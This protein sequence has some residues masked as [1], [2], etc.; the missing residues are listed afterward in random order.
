M[1]TGASCVPRPLQGPTSV[2][3]RLLETEQPLDKDIQQLCKCRKLG[4]LDFYSIF[5]PSLPYISMAYFW[6]G[7][8]DFDPNSKNFTHIL[9]ALALY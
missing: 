2:A 1:V 6:K 8:A 3:S 7:L 5:G 4:S 9:P